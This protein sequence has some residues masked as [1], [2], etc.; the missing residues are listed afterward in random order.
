MIPW[1]WAMS[2]QM[3]FVIVVLALLV[4]LYARYEEDILDF[5]DE[6]LWKIGGRR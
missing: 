2:M 6:V 4:Y 5:L 3:A 1:R